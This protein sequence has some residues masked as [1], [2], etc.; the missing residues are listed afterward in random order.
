[1]EHVYQDF[2]KKNENDKTLRMY[3]MVHNIFFSLT[4]KKMTF[5]SDDELEKLIHSV[6]SDD[7]FIIPIKEIHTT[8]DSDS[9]HN[10]M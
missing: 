8:N 2:M 6:S 4:Q 7:W 9:L 3:E 5:M 10:F 1:M